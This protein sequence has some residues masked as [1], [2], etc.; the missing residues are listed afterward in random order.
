MDK[1]PSEKA[2]GGP[3]RVPKNKQKLKT[4]IAYTSDFIKE[5]EFL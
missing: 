1:M 3:Q 4:Q 5:V 2:G